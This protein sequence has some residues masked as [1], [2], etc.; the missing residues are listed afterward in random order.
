MRLATVRKP[1][2]RRMTATER[3]T[4]FPNIRNDPGMRLAT[5]E[6][7][8]ASADTASKKAPRNK[9]NSKCLGHGARRHKANNAH[10]R[11][12]LLPCFAHS[13]NAGRNRE[14]WGPNLPQ[15]GRHRPQRSGETQQ[16]PT[17]QRQPNPDVPRALRRSSAG[18]TG[19]SYP[20]VARRRPILGIRAAEDQFF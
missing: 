1:S 19:T 11:E 10:R 20:S 12:I 15:K 16:A 9:L 17:Q 7:R 3:I 8:H 18:S 14:P 5:R 13:D 4:R 6:R 2:S